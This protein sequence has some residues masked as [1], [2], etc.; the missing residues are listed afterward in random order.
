VRVVV[1]QVERVLLRLTEEGV[2]EAIGSGAAQ[3]Y[4]CRP[5]NPAD[6]ASE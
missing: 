4:R 3:Y 6:G 1:A 5:A 2:L